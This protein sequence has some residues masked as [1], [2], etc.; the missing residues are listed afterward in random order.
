LDFY[1]K[2]IGSALAIYIALVIGNTF[3]NHGP[4]FCIFLSLFTMPYYMFLALVYE[5]GK[6]EGKA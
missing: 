5:W 4:V 2:H 1:L 6:M 3:V